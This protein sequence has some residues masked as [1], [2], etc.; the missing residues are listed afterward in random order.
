MNHAT[1][2]NVKTI[3]AASL[4]FFGTQASVDAWRQGQLDAERAKTQNLDTTN[5]DNHGQHNQ[6]S[7]NKYIQSGCQNHT[8]TSANK[9]IILAGAHTRYTRTAY[10]DTTYRAHSDR[11]TNHSRACSQ[12]AGGSGD[13]SNHSAYGNY[14]NYRNHSNCNHVNSGVN[15]HVNYTQ[16][17]C[18]DVIVTKDLGFDH[19]NYVPSQPKVF[20]MSESLASAGDVKV[21]GVYDLEVFSFDKNNDGVGTNDTQSKTVKYTVQIEKVKDRS[22]N[23]VSSAVYTLANKSTSNKISVNT[24]APLGIAVSKENSEGVY[25]VSIVAENDPLSRTGTISE[26]GVVT[27]TIQTSKTYVSSTTVVYMTIQQDVPPK[28]TVTN[29]GEFNGAD[30]GLDGKYLSSI[31]KKWGETQYAGGNASQQDGLLV[32]V[33]LSD[34]DVGD[35]HSG[36]VYLRKSIS[37]LTSKIPIVWLPDKAGNKTGFAYIPKDEFLND[38]NNED[39]SIV[40]EIQSYEDTARTISKGDRYYF[41][42]ISEGGPSMLVDVDVVRPDITFSPD[43]PKPDIVDADGINNKVSM[44]FTDSGLGVRERYYQVI[45]N[46]VLTGSEPYD[47]AN[48]TNSAGDVS[49][50]CDE[51]NQYMLWAKVV[52]NAGNVTFEKSGIYKIAPIELDAITNPAYP[53]PIWRRGEVA[54][55]AVSESK[56]N[57]VKAEAWLIGDPTNTKIELTT[58]D[59]G[60]RKRWT[61]DI[62]LPAGISLGDTNLIVKCYTDDANNSTVYT[63]QTSVQ[64]RIAEAPASEF[65]SLSSLHTSD[66]NDNRKAFNVKKTGTEESPR[67][68]SIFWSGEKLLIS[69]DVHG[70]V[71][72]IDAEIVG[73]PEYHIQNLTYDIDPVT[74]SIQN[75]QGE[76]WDENMINRWGKVTPETLTLRMTVRYFDWEVN[77][78]TGTIVK[79]SPIV[80]DTKDDYWNVHQ[81]Y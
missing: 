15:D 65:N 79:D 40:M 62:R 38:G 53:M 64:V 6:T 75:V 18:T 29:A 30:L 21:R 32:Q 7:E 26:N 56:H 78:T 52:D 36:T 22:G 13:H 58:M 59:T 16:S 44:S 35:Y 55:N 70:I 31:F 48:W 28:L 74:Y 39:V 51:E 67:T 23:A 50:L 12:S 33:N 1:V 10:R 37:I 20:E 71:D 73:Y 17:V 68:E 9:K 76:I 57:I 69:A 5:Y 49:F 3:E 4:L 25:K 60:D 34:E 45:S 47:N 11:P 42:T 61:G 54:V 19:Q 24:L 2:Q 72:S 27:Q 63:K 43:P 46:T 81:L 77:A 80:F 66:W 14:G 8:N 41:T